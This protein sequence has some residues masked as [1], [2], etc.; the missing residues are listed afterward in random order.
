M[1]TMKIT[2]EVYSGNSAIDFFLEKYVTLLQLTQLLVYIGR[3]FVLIRIVPSEF[4]LHKA[5]M[6]ERRETVW[7]N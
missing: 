4:V 3:Y 2:V 6:I 1:M 5:I 7:K